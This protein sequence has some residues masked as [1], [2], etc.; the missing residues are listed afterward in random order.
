MQMIVESSAS[1][2]PVKQWVEAFNFQTGNYDLINTDPLTT[3]DVRRTYGVPDPAAHVGPGNT[4]RCR[5]SFKSQ[6]P[7]FAY[8]WQAR[9]DELT[10]KILD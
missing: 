2:T 5:V 6:G 10:W 8:P 3:S 7:I 1:S 9:V 4:V